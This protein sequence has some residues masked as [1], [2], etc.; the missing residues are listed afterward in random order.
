VAVDG[1]PPIWLTNQIKENGK[2]DMGESKGRKGVV[3]KV[4][5]YENE[6][7]LF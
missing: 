7:G 2:G 1:E 4:F 6:M 3:K 5:C